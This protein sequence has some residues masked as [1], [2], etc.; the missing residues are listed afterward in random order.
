MLNILLFFKF[1]QQIIVS[2]YLYVN[3]HS[4]IT[5]HHKK[6]L[7]HSSVKMS[8]TRNWAFTLNALLRFRYWD[9]YL[10]FYDL[11]KKCS[12]DASG[13]GRWSAH[14]LAKISLSSRT[15][16]WTFFCVVMQSEWKWF[17]FPHWNT[18]A[19]Y[20]LYKND[21]LV[22]FKFKRYIPSRYSDHE[23]V[24]HICCNSTSSVSI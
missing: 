13:H 16:V 23:T 2:T 10:R 9:I 6:M 3:I 17:F 7:V 12:L 20:S 8:Y 11:Q 18:H 14:N 1:N 21:Q 15:I 19:S 5:K 22:E 24:L 4:F